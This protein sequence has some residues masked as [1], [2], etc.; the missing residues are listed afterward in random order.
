MARWHHR[1]NGHELS[2]VWVLVMDSEAW[3]A[4]VHG[5]NKIWTWPSDWTE[6]SWCYQHH[7]SPYKLIY[8]FPSKGEKCDIHLSFF[9]ASKGTYGR[10][11]TQLLWLSLPDIFNRTTFFIS[12]LPLT[13]YFMLGIKLLLSVRLFVEL[14]LIL[15]LLLSKNEIYRRNAFLISVYWT[16]ERYNTTNRRREKCPGG[17][18]ML[19]CPDITHSAFVKHRPWIL[20]LIWSMTEA[21]KELIWRTKARLMLKNWSFRTP[22][23]EKTLENPLDCKEIKP[24][25]TK[26]NQPWLF[27]GRTDA[28][29]ETPILWPPDEKSQLIGKN[30]DAGKDIRQEE[31]GTTEYEMA[32]WHHGLNGHES[33]Q[34]PGD[35]DGQGSLVCWSP[36]SH[37]VRHYLVTERC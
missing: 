37:R 32:G 21:F 22:M 31:K 3:R 16:V 24:V 10:L 30:P 1:L 13:F 28:K 12:V 18:R 11:G 29:A 2:K 8:L 14:I 34:T 33:E 17:W 20:T 15:T 4:A 26:G 19:V 23:L 36:W 7:N 9:Q 5:V 27:I 35:S 6:D 25:N